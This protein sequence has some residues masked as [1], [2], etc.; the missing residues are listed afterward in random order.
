M[1]NMILAPNPFMH[2]Y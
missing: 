1:G 2:E